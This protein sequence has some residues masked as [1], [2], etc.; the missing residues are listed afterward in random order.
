LAIGT[1]TKLL[2]KP[3]S[4]FAISTFPKMNLPGQRA[5]SRAIESGLAALWDFYAAHRIVMNICLEFASFPGDEARMR[6]RPITIAIVVAIT[7]LLALAFWK[8]EVKATDTV[9]QMP[10]YGIS[11]NSYLPIH[12]LRPAY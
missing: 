5:E 2:L 6:K 1:N 12:R 11:A 9:L 7:S 3:S 10:E 8:V 4:R